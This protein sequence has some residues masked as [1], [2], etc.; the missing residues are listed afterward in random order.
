LRLYSKLLTLAHQA[1]ASYTAYL[2]RKKNWKKQEPN[3]RKQRKKQL[4]QPED[5]TEGASR[6][7]ATGVFRGQS[8]ES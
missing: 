4:L 1:H 2:E 5:S 8:E 3:K 6:T 7:E